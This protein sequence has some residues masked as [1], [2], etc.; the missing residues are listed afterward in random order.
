MPA[1][2]GGPHVTRLH[3]RKYSRGLMWCNFTSR[4]T[5]SSPT[6]SA[7]YTRICGSATHTH[8]RSTASSPYTGSIRNLNLPLEN[9]PRLDI[10]AI[11]FFFQRWESNTPARNPSLLLSLY[12]FFS[13]SRFQRLH[14][15]STNCRSLNFHRNSHSSIYDLRFYLRPRMRLSFPFEN[16]SR[17][18]FARFEGRPYL[19]PLLR[20][21]R[22]LIYLEEEEKEE[23]RPSARISRIAEYILPRFRHSD[24]VHD[25]R[26][27]IVHLKRP[28]TILFSYS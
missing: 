14:R 10:K 28:G 17:L 7:C 18:L 9:R 24:K 20:T 3:S 5:R 8:A 4:V 2:R 13:W 27:S 11:F 22:I 21:R 25:N 1:T 23:N 26:S 16:R 19:F 12:F 15:A 6:V